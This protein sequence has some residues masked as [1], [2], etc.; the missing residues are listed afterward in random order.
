MGNPNYLLLHWIV[1]PEGRRALNE[2]VVD[3][4]ASS[5]EKIGLRIPI[6][7][8]IVE[9][10]GG[11]SSDYTLVAGAHRLAATEKL[12]WEGVDC[13]VYRDESDDQAK[14]WEISENLHRAE[15]TALERSEQI[16]EWI[17]ITEKLSA[18]LAPKGP[19][20]HRPESGIN[21]ASLELGVERTEAQRATKIAGLSTEAKTVAIEV[22]LDDNKSALLA[23]AKQPPEQQAPYVRQTAQAKAA[24]PAKVKRGII[25]PDEF[26]EAY[27]EKVEFLAHCARPADKY[28]REQ[29]ARLG[30]VD[31]G[32]P[33][34]SDL[35]DDLIAYRAALEEW[36]R[37]LWMQ[38]N[39]THDP[40]ISKILVAFSAAIEA[41]DRH[42]GV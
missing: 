14:L 29:E 42:G 38:P 22:G 2:V 30:P 13:I 35:R 25:P 9:Y 5:M 41:I 26:T 20:G 10:P 40:G 4:I 17:A 18:Q 39:Y 27:H 12:G 32:V 34:I 6:S 15:L 33:K 31:S 16:A 23:A 3:Q 36:M 21:K 28:F 1:V 8:R 37:N 7:V 19:I 11:D 24:A